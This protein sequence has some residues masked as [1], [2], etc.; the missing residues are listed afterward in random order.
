MTQRAQRSAKVAKEIE[1][2]RREEREVF[3]QVAVDTVGAGPT[4][5]VGLAVLFLRLA[6]GRNGAIVLA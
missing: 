3:W 5:L 6:S 2:W 1:E 4:G